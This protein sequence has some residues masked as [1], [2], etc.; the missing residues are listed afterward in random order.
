MMQHPQTLNPPLRIVSAALALVAALG[1][2]IAITL[3][4]VDLPSLGPVAPAEPIVR[5][6]SDAVMDSARQWERQ[7]LQQ[8]GADDL[9]DAGRDW[10]RQRRQQSPL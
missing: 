8:A 9:T 1:A 2:G 10:E 7:R 4:A 3:G 5:P 6:A